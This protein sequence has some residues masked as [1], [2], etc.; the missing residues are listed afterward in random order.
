VGRALTVNFEYLKDCFV[1][2]VAFAAAS[3]AVAWLF[4][5]DDTIRDYLSQ[6]RD[7]TT[8]VLAGWVFWN[9][10]VYDAVRKTEQSKYTERLK[11]AARRRRR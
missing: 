10:I 7:I 11:G 4:G 2:I 1:K 3:N 6:H 8:L 5:V 9:Y